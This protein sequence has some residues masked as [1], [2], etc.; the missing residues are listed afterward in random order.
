MKTEIKK[1]AKSD[2]YW[3]QIELSLIQLTGIEDGYRAARDGVQPLGARIDLSANGLLLLNLITELGELEQALNRTKK[4]FE[5]SDGRCSAIVKVLEDGSDLFVSHNSWSGY[6]TM[7]RILK[8]YNLNYKNIAGQHISFSSYPG[9]I[10][11]IDDYYLISSGLLVLET[12][13]GNYNN[14]LWPKVVADKVVFEFIRNTVANRMAR[15]GKEWSQIFAKFNSGTYNNQFMIIDYNKFEKGV[16]PSDLANDVLWIVEQIP[17]YIESADVTHVLREQHYWPSYNVPYF[18]SI[19][20]MSDYTSQYIKYGDFFSYEKTA[21]ALIFR[22]DQNKVTDLDSLY[23]LMR[24]NDFKND[25]LSRCNCSP[26]Y[27][28]EYAIAARCDLN[29]PNGRYPIDSLGF[30]SHG[31][32]DVKLT[33]SDLFSRL[34]MIANSGPSYEEQPPFQWSN[35]RIVGVL[36]SGQPDTFKFPAVHVKWTPTL[37]HPISFR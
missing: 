11:S 24:Y 13:I 8:K 16:K 35:T 2:E 20:D 5:L 25:P 31:A 27:T 18:K 14:S 21:R 29:D 36:H 33:N 32:I 12:S 30:R 1:Y 34:E 26:P 4:T 17:G 7:L 6:S 10:F 3:H 9:I 28:A 15:T 23:K 37:M 22:R 19:Y